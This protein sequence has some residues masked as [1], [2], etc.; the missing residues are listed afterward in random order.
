MSFLPRSRARAKIT[1]PL[2]VL[3]LQG[4]MT[5]PQEED[6]RAA[7]LRH[8]GVED[9]EVRLIMHSYNVYTNLCGCRHVI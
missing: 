2:A 6:V 4:M 8:E 3:V 1:N 9:A 5:V 7:F